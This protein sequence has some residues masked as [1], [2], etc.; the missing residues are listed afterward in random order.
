MSRVALS[1]QGWL[2]ELKV[3]KGSLIATPAG[4]F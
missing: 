2:M 4:L 3:K 1:L